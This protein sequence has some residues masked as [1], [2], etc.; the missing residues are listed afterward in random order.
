MIGNVLD[1]FESSKN[2]KG[3]ISHGYLC[4]TVDVRCSSGGLHEFGSSAGAT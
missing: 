1:K 2:T 3:S 4:E